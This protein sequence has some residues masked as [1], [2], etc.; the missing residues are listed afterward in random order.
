MI[1]ADLGSETKIKKGLFDIGY[2]YIVEQHTQ[3]YSKEFTK[4]LNDKEKTA[5]LLT[6]SSFI[7]EPFQKWEEQRYFISTAIDKSGTCLDVGCGN[8]F[9]TKCLVEW[10]GHKLIPYG[11]DVNP[12]YIDQAKELFPTYKKNFKVVN[13]HTKLPEVNISRQLWLF[14]KFDFLIWN[15][16][17]NY[18]FKKDGIRNLKFC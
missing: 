14:K 3:S 15:V 8:G 4:L 12:E 9:L 7:N 1:N 11:I 13:F 10:S 17:D 2:N 5:Q 16:W 18:Y 6:G